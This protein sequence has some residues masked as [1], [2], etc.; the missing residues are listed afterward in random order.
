MNLFELSVYGAIAISG[1]VALWCA[2]GLGFGVIAVLFERCG[3]DD[4]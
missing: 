4:D 3:H 2:L 1:A